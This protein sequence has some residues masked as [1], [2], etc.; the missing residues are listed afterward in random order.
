VWIALGSG[1]RFD[2]K[3]KITGGSLPPSFW[4]I[5]PGSADEPSTLSVSGLEQPPELRKSSRP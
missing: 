3:A 1:P 5:D 2:L 4:N